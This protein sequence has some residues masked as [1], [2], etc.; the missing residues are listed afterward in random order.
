MREASLRDIAAAAGDA[1][2][3][4]AGNDKSKGRQDARKL[5]SY[6]TKQYNKW[7]GQTGNEI[8]EESLMTFLSAKIGFTPANIRKIFDKAKVSDPTQMESL[9][10]DIN[11]TDVDR[12]MQ[13]A[14]EFAFAHNLVKPTNP[15]ETPMASREE[16]RRDGRRRNRDEG[17]P[18]DIINSL[19]NR[20]ESNKNAYNVDKTELVDAL[21]QTG[22]TRE[23]LG[24]LTDIMAKVKDYKDI[25]KMP[26]R[27]EIMNQLAKVGF[28]FFKSTR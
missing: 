2:G 17:S 19:R 10:E 25:Q 20:V 13:I 28:A 16:P 26:D 5:K 8:D 11:K 4:M 14:A 27:N 1:V 3:A 18:D 7:L 6:L 21:K 22:L 23:Y 12:V 9:Q 24:D 15:E